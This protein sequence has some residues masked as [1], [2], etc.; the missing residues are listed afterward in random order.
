MHAELI[1]VRAQLLSALATI[2]SL[3]A[4]EEP[5]AQGA[6]SYRTKPGG[7]LS[8][9][10]IAEM[11]RRFEANQPDVVIARAMAVS[12]QGCQK[13]RGIWKRERERG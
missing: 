9:E 2:D 8:E 6:A 12:I 5:G 1:N 7:P 10:G 11:Y 13:R 4:A 3:L